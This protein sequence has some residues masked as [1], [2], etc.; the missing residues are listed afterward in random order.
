MQKI[1]GTQ[2]RHAAKQK[3]LFHS[4]GNQIVELVSKEYHRMY[5]QLKKKKKRK[6]I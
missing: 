4:H 3:A 2:A 6:D 5:I 1:R